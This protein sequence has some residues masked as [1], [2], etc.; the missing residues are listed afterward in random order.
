MNC[1]AACYM[2]HTWLLVIM[3]PGDDNTSTTAG[4]NSDV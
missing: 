3:A 2:I 1:R 4:G